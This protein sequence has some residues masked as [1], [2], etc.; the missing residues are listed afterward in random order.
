MFLVT[1]IELLDVCLLP[2]NR[3]RW[4]LMILAVDAGNL[5]LIELNR[6]G[7][8]HLASVLAVAELWLIATLVILTGGGLWSPATATYLLIVFGA[9]LLLGESAGDSSLEE[10]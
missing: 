4:I 8:T 1:V 5:S 6:R 3:W 7:R 10:S 9:G 2:E